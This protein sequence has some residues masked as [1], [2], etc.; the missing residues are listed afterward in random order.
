M[1]TSVHLIVQ[2]KLI[3][4]KKKSSCHLISSST[5]FLATPQKITN[6][7]AGGQKIPALNYVGSLFICLS[8][9]LT[10]QGFVLLGFSFLIHNTMKILWLVNCVSLC[11]IF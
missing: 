7:K 2:L 6:R 3:Q 5:M 8:F 9:S 11:I 1:Q 10:K 4:W